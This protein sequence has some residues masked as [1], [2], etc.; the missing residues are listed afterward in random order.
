LAPSGEDVVARVSIVMDGKTL[1]S[2]T[3]G[4][5]GKDQGVVVRPAVPRNLPIEILV[6]PLGFGKTVKACVVPSGE[7]TLTISVG[8]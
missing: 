2:H 4:V 8:K 1:S 6:E 7:A 5:L 3:L